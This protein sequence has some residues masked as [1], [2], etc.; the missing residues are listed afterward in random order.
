MTDLTETYRSTICRLHDKSK[1]F[2]PGCTES[3]ALAVN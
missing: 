1:L 3:I 2:Q